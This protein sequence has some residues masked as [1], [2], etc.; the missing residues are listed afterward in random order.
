MIST[1]SYKNYN[2][3]K[4]MVNAIDDRNPNYPIYKDLFY[5]DVSKEVY[6]NNMNNLSD[7][8]NKKR[9]IS[10]YYKEVL[11]KLDPVEVYKY[12]DNSVIL[13][14][15]DSQELSN[16]YMVACW[17][18]LF[19]NVTIDEIKVN[20]Y[21]IERIDRPTYIKEYLE[22]IIRS[23]LDMGDFKSLMAYFYYQKGENLEQQANLVEDKMKAN[24]MKKEANALR[25]NAFE[26]EK[27]YNEGLKR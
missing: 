19:L 20:D 7:E 13:S 14:E 27:N 23:S 1:S 18:E 12:L 24:D 8:D 10:T 15:E 4:Y 22:D 21:A 11:S 3:D 26:I 2:S 17:L 5:S 16:R 25:D 9:L 6:V